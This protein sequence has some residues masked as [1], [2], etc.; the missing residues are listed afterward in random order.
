MIKKVITEKEF[1]MINALGKNGKIIPDYVKMVKGNDVK[2]ALLMT[3]VYYLEDL[4]YE[5]VL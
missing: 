1:K 3:G 5:V 2:Y 4:G